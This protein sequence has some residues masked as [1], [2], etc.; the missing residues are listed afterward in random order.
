MDQIDQLSDL[1]ADGGVLVITGAG[2]STDSG[3]PD[4]RGSGQP[5]R[6]SI[7]YDDFIGQEHWRKHLWE[8]NEASWRLLTSVEPAPAH[9]ALAALEEAGLLTGIIT[10]NVDRLHTRAGSRQVAEMHGRFDLVRCVSCDAALEREEMSR[11]LAA[12][13]PSFEPV[14]VTMDQIEILPSLDP[15]ARPTL[16]TVPPCPNC[17]GILKPDVVF[18][19]E[20]IPEAATALAQSYAAAARSVLVVGSSLYVSTVH[21]YLW[22]TSELPLAIVNRGPTAF[23]F[24]ADIRIYDG[25]SEVLSAV[26]DR[27][28]R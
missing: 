18:F 8:R 2:M 11:L 21:W 17:G 4:Y 9:R 16:A 28:V 22:R 15:Q 1:V 10:Q 3:V 25:A 13:N 7:E 19:G 26:V 27:V 12:A 20:L 23:D 24:D 5:E 6:P 14:P